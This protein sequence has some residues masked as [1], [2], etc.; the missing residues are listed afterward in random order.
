M[1]GPEPL[2][3]GMLLR[4]LRIAAALSQE[5]LAER[6]GISARAVGDL[7]R[8]VHQV[9]RLETVRLLADALN[10]TAQDRAALLAA[11]RPTAMNVPSETEGTPRIP[12]L[13]HSPVR[14]IGREREL[15]A[16]C[17]L[18]VQ[19]EHQLVTLTGP[20]G[21]GKT[22][23]AQ[24][25]AA[26]L[27]S[28]FPDG[29]W[30]VDLSPL[31]DADL[32]LSTIAAALG[33]PGGREGLEIRLQ[34]FLGGKPTLLVL[35]NFEHVVEAGS[36]VA[37]ILAHA[38]RLRVLV[39]SRMPLHVQGEQEYPLPPLPFP[40][41]SC[42]SSWEA[43]E[44]SPAVQ[45]FV[46]RAQAIQPDFRLSPTNGQA[47]SAICQRLD[48]LPLAI[49]LAA[50][51]VR[52]MP[53]AALLA[54]LEKRLPLL[55][56]GA[57]TLP[58][59]QRTMRDAIAWSYDLLAPQ[60]QALFRRLAVFVG[61]FTF[62]AAEAMAHPD[63]S[64]AA[65]DGVV[66]LVEHSL[67]RQIAGADEEPRFLML[68]TV[69]EFGLEQLALAGDEHE[70]RRQHA[71]HYLRFTDELAPDSSIW[72]S[73]R[74]RLERMT[75]DVANV[76]Q[77]FTWFEAHDEAEALLRMI[78]VYWVLWQTSGR[79]REGLAMIERVLERS[80]PQASVAR[81]DALNGAVKLALEHGAF[82]LGATCSAEELLLAKE[83]GDPLLIGWGLCNAGLVAS[84][85]GEL[86]R[87]AAF[88]AE[89][90]QV[91]R[92]GGHMELEGWA[93][94]W[95]GDMALA[96]GHRD[97]ATSHYGEALAFFQETNWAWGLVD[98]NAG[99]GGVHF[100]SGD[101]AR[102]LAHYGESLERAWH[103]G[104]P[105]LAIGSLLG[106][107]GV[108]AESGY[109][110]QGARLFGAAEGIMASIGAPVFPRDHP[111]RD[112]ALAALAAALDDDRLATMRDSGRTL[113]FQ[114]VVSEAKS[115][116]EQISGRT[117]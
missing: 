101:L 22:R 50:A 112:H 92:A 15:A 111:A 115:V 109:A 24:E 61:G 34:G 114:Q 51:R 1:P 5:A 56:G 62:E 17:D 78:G 40:D 71:G 97:Q 49:E 43:V 88:F 45:L 81:I 90:L 108:F 79:Y 106:L 27:T 9:P 110:E 72:L 46:E 76:Q 53:P 66:T 11:A 29:V 107:A 3:L 59:R 39:T 64:L 57:R 69:R 25:V 47:I 55:T 75:G 105:V 86:G 31:T 30:F 83:L 52:V 54:R 10:L 99:L 117:H 12:S 7:E 14:I 98:V 4:Q 19:D 8:G 82:A 20:G 58:A 36:S 28:R 91:G 23:L 32:V 74:A 93:N 77:A 2:P 33:L 18:L 42:L 103:V 67:L 38:S 80:R 21:T 35:D 41:T 104:V 95:I 60:E 100:G 44:H 48:G 13:P 65:F 116:A 26:R 16:L 73:R 84:R 102:A 6:A 68:E 96:K 113:T 63:G 89:A 85:F 87:A 70:A 37:T 94:L